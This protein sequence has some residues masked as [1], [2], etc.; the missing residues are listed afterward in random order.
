MA[1]PANPTLGNRYYT[2]TQTWEWDGAA[3]RQVYGVDDS[4]LQRVNPDEPTGQ[5]Y[6][7]VLGGVA[8]ILE[9]PAENDL[10]RYNTGAWRN[11]P[12]TEIVDGGNF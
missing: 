4:A 9:A 8:L 10:L 11:T 1:F 3:W 6:G 5:V 2:H 7:P 12:Q